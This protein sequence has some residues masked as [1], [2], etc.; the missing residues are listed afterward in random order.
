MRRPCLPWSFV[1]CSLLIHPVLA[2]DPV[3]DIRRL[4]EAAAFQE[5]LA[6]VD[7]TPID[8]RDAASIAVQYRALS[9]VA[10][11]RPAEA[12]RAMTAM[13]TANPMNPITI[14][15]VPPRVRAMMLRLWRPFMRDF[16]ERHYRD[17]KTAYRAGAWMEASSA[18]ETVI[19][20][21]RHPELEF[22]GDPRLSD[23]GDLA[24]EYLELARTRATDAHQSVL[25]GGSQ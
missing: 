16:I 8:D 13:I 6:A 4:Y 22:E 12:E 21:V 7:T 1:L 17:G 23:V 11:R 3:A 24:A 10:L 20:A 15:H 18:F 14:P 2:Q 9:L 5:V 25:P 19:S